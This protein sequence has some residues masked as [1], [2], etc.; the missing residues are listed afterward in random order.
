MR[1][2]E[3]STD[4][5]QKPVSV[6]SGKRLVKTLSVVHDTDTDEE[7]P[8]TIHSKNKPI[9]SISKL[10][11]PVSRSSSR[12]GTERVTQHESAA[13][14]DTTTAR[15]SSKSR[16]SVT[17]KFKPAESSGSSD[18]SLPPTLPPK[19]R[20]TRTTAVPTRSGSGSFR[21]SNTR[22]STSARAV[23]QPASPSPSSSS[24]LSPSPVLP[25]V[26]SSPFVPSPNFSPSPSPI[27]SPK[28]TRQEVLQNGSSP[29]EQDDD[30]D[31]ALEYADYPIPPST[32]PAGQAQA[33]PK[34][35]L[36]LQSP[37][38]SP[39]PSPPPSPRSVLKGDRKS[40]TAE[41][42]IVPETEA[43]ESKEPHHQDLALTLT[44]PLP[45]KLT[46]ST[47]KTRPRTS[48]SDAVPLTPAPQKPSLSRSDSF[49]ARMKPRTP[50][51]KRNMPDADILELPHSFS[52]GASPVS[53]LL[54]A[55]KAFHPIPRISPSKFPT[56]PSTIESA[57]TRD[58]MDEDTIEQFDSPDKSVIRRAKQAASQ[59][60]PESSNGSGGTSGG[61][62][63]VP[64]AATDVL[65]KGVAMAERAKLNGNEGANGVLPTQA[66]T[67]VSLARLVGKAKVKENAPRDVNVNMDGGAEV[68]HAALEKFADSFV[69]YEGGLSE[70][71][72]EQRPDVSS[73]T[74]DMASGATNAQQQKVLLRQEEE[75]STQDL[76]MDLEQQRPMPDAN[77]GWAH[78][79]VP[80]VASSQQQQSGDEEMVDAVNSLEVAPPKGRYLR[81]KHL[82]MK[83]VNP[84][85]PLS[86]LQTNF[87]RP[88][89]RWI[90][91][92]KYQPRYP[93]HVHKCLNYSSR[94]RTVTNKTSIPR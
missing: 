39:T 84:K 59:E 50:G 14:E 30:Y 12:T 13:S 15:R 40:H 31:S 79:V 70:D 60:V 85:P 64:P 86:S 8:K 93:Q 23:K 66:Q 28:A 68:E 36:F 58:G 61:S 44:M 7:P 22:L 35:T 56:L 16:K 94:H 49:V 75:E 43:E 88:V 62:L 65:K 52:N 6:K 27:L 80:D 47:S 34:P 42:D 21:V 1:E 29:N 33:Q 2:E 32:P 71:R 78:P 19:R 82:K 81:Y 54:H 67:K 55:K 77:G 73:R 38:A 18:D 48:S 45:T 37:T 17:K 11:P 83:R 90:V 57:D 4:N 3:G 53:P 25:T 9:N 5:E 10:T 63:P 76:L 92:S 87:L 51:S 89:A 24:F 26:H 69:D 72:Q 91:H 41:A 74:E 46:P 20:P